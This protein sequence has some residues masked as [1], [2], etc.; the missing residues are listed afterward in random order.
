MRETDR[1]TESLREEIEQEERERERESG[2]Q[3]TGLQCLFNIM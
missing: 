3:V 1:Q 2:S